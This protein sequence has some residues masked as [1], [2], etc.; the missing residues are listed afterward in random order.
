MKT[1][2]MTDNLDLIKIWWDLNENKSGWERVGAQSF[3][4]YLYDNGYKV[5]KDE[6]ES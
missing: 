4:S 6:D 2:S 3:I 5:V 1:N